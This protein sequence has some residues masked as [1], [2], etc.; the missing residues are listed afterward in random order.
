[1]DHRRVKSFFLMPS[2]YYEG[3]MYMETIILVISV[4]EII[5]S[6]ISVVIDIIK[7]HKIEKKK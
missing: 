5:L 7:L 1:M 3:G 6:F 2:E 4:V